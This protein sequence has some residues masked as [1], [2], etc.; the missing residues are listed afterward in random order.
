MFPIVMSSLG[1]SGVVAGGIF[2]QYQ[3]LFTV[4]QHRVAG[5]V[6]DRH[7]DT[8]RRHGGESDRDRFF[9]YCVCGV[10][11]LD[12]SHVVFKRLIYSLVLGLA[13]L[14]PSPASAQMT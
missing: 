7:H 1:L 6:G 14:M 12:R 2:A 4:A 10:A 13:C 8:Q 5:G 3:P 11:F 9:G